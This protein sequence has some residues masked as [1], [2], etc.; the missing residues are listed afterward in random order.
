M[1][2]VVV[3]TGDITAMPVEAIVNAA[4]SRLAAGGGVCGA[5]FAADGPRELSEAC[6]AIGSCSTGSAV[7]TSSHCLGARGIR[8]IVHAVGPV[9]SATDESTPEAAAL[10]EQLASTYRSALAV[11]DG[12]GVRSIAFP[13]I[14]TGIY[15]FPPS[16]A[17]RIASDVVLGYAGPIERI[18]LVAFDEPA[19]ALLTEAV[20]GR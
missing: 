9:W 12:L 13:C 1:A 2:E 3:V 8:H 6:E 16:R 10:D 17:A 4:N 5:I 18:V 15:G 11:A 19:A 14:S 7:A 20:A